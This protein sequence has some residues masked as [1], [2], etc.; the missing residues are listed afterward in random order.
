MIELWH[1]HGKYIA[2]QRRWWRGDVTGSPIPMPE[3][4]R[5]PSSAGTPFGRLLFLFVIFSFVTSGPSSCL[6]CNEYKMLADDMFPL[7]SSQAVGQ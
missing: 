7:P 1:R 3:P 2:A 6:C 5:G 4:K